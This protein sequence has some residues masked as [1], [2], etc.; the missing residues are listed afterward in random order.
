ME[1]EPFLKKAKLWILNVWDVISDFFKELWDDH[2]L[3]CLGVAFF[4]ILGLSILITVSSVKSSQNKALLNAENS[5]T[6]TVEIEP[7]LSIPPE[8]YVEDAYVYSRKNVTRWSDE[9]VSQWFT[10]PDEEMLEDLKDANN[11]LIEDMMEVVP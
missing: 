3:I 5:N 9:S 11:K 2:R 6:A 7:F 8:P 1:K 10:E 4:I